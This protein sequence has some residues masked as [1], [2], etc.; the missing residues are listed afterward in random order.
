MQNSSI[1]Q[2][3]QTHIQFQHSTCSLQFIWHQYN[4]RDGTDKVTYLLMKNL[5]RNQLCCWN[6]PHNQ[7]PAW[8]SI[9]QQRCHPRAGHDSS[10]DKGQCRLTHSQGTQSATNTTGFTKP[11][12]SEDQ[13]LYTCS[14]NNPFT[15]LWRRQGKPTGDSPNQQVKHSS[16]HK[17]THSCSWP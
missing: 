14:K 6:V 9:S 2:R 3:K 10:K 15:A 13:P 17:T 8:S 1:I 4:C 12:Q 11:A 16:S 7:G 5:S